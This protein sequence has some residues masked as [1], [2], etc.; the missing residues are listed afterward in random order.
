MHILYFCWCADRSERSNAW[1]SAPEAAGMSCKAASRFLY[2]SS[3]RSV[4][5]PACLQPCLPD[6][7]SGTQV[8]SVCSPLHRTYRNAPHRTHAL[9]GSATDPQACV[10]TSCLSGSVYADIVTST[11]GPSV[12]MHPTFS[13]DSDVYLGLGRGK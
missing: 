11:G 8:V 1:W 9:M 5:R 6:S 10:D 13:P 4:R 3:A 7:T 2:A 12:H